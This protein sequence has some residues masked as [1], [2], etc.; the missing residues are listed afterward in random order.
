MTAYDLPSGA[1]TVIKILSRTLVLLNIKTYLSTFK[2]T[3]VR[4]VASN[5]D[6]HSSYFYRIRWCK[7]YKGFVFA[8]IPPNQTQETLSGHLEDL[9]TSALIVT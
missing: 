9:A 8:F 6:A 2:A 7:S 5:I 1:I 4:R 3:R